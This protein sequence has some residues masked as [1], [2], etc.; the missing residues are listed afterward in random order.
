[1]LLKFVRG[2]RTFEEIRTIN[3][4]TYATFKQAC[5][6]LGILCDDNEWNHAIQEA[7]QLA[8]TTQMH[9]LFTILLLFCEIS[10]R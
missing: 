10:A 1:M 5:R 3:G 4:V 9:E 6:A 8:T 2:T 7:S